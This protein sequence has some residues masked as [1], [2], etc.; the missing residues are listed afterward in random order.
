MKCGGL[1]RRIYIPHLNAEIIINL[2]LNLACCECPPEFMNYE[3]T[4]D[5]TDFMKMYAIYTPGKLLQHLWACMF[6]KCHLQGGG[7]G[8]GAE[9]SS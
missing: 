7:G 3:H 1:A 5:A 8:G 9:P 2:L 6:K 4:D